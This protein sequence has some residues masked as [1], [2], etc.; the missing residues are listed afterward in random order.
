[1]TLINLKKFKVPKYSTFDL[2]R[3]VLK[4][5]RIIMRMRLDYLSFVFGR[6]GLDGDLPKNI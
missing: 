1:M 6:H 2:F 4:Y 3:S 5:N